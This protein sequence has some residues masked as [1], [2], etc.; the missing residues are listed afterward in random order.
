MAL[1]PLT[2]TNW[3][4]EN[5]M[6]ATISSLGTHW[7]NIV[8]SQS[9]SQTGRETEAL[10]YYANIY[11][12][13]TISKN[14]NWSTYKIMLR[15][16][17]QDPLTMHLLIAASLIDLAAVRNYDEAICCAARLHAKE[18]MMLLKAA[19]RPDANSDPI[20]VM[21][22]FFFL[23][24]YTALVKGR[25]TLQ[26]ADWSQ[27]V[28]NYVKTNRLQDVCSGVAESQAEQRR[29]SKTMPQQMRTH[30]ARLILWTFYEDVYAGFGG[31]GGFLARHMCDE[32]GRARDVYQHSSA[33]LE[34][35]WGKDYPEREVID[36]LENAPVIAFL[37]EV[38]SLYAEVNKVAVSTQPSD[39]EKAAIQRKIE[40]LEAVSKGKP[41]NETVRT[42]I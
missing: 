25:D 29:T 19:L 22:A 9:F 6:P 13:M 30:L 37:Y 40:K 33:E 5:D 17:S 21:T 35:F 4:R 27:N 24:R 1:Q 16:N 38:M 12:T 20:S 18:G 15:N 23:Y 26:M 39:L 10:H 36:D 42:P 41:T 3:A 28:C 11:P 8:L 32:P 31:Q 7:Q 2:Q 14:L 34:C